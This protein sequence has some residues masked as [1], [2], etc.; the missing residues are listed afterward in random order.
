MVVSGLSSGAAPML[1]VIALLVQ[2]TSK[3]TYTLLA[4]LTLDILGPPTSN[5]HRHACQDILIDW[6]MTLDS[7]HLARIKSVTL[8]G[9]IKTVLKERWHEILEDRYTYGT[10]PYLTQ[11]GV[12][13]HAW[14]QTPPECMCK[15]PCTLNSVS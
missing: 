11:A 9:Y 13:K 8:Q 15:F 2:W 5:R 3:S 6:I 14:A 12:I 4:T 7:S 10:R 1:P